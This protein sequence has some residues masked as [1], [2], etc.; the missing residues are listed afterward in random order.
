LN[1]ILLRLHPHAALSFDTS[2]A[3]K[4]AS[5]LKITFWDFQLFF[6]IEGVKEFK[7]AKQLSLTI[8]STKIF[9]I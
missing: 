1:E 6:I 9:Y 8:L 7:N 4:C 3:S 5:K 2:N